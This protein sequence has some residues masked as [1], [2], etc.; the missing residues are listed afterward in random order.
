MAISGPMSILLR[1]EKDAPHKFPDPKPK[2]DCEVCAL[3]L[4][5]IRADSDGGMNRGIYT[6]LTGMIASQKLLD[7]TANNLAND[8]R[9]YHDGLDRP[10]YP[11]ADYSPH[12][13]ASGAM[14]SRTL[15][16]TIGVLTA[17]IGVPFF[18]W[19]VLKRR[20]ADRYAAPGAMA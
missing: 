1:T 5:N 7:V 10:G 4:A 19:L 11:R 6:A 15:L 17:L 3:N 16:V 14:S 2:V 12:P 9:D 18:I 20:R 13:I 8:W